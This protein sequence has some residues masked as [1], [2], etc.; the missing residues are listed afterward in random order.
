MGYV[1]RDK[2]IVRIDHLPTSGNRAS[3][4]FL[5]LPMFNVTLPTERLLAALAADIPPTVRTNAD[6]TST[7]KAAKAHL[8]AVLWMQHGIEVPVFVWRGQLAVRISVPSY[9]SLQDI[10]RLGRAV[11]EICGKGRV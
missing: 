11:L 5:P 1:I 7:L 6:A 4:T 2:L 9:V 3:S 10:H 8:N